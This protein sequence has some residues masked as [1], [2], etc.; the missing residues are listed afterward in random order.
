LLKRTAASAGFRKAAI[1]LGYLAAVFR[2]DKTKRIR[3]DKRIQ[4]KT[5]QGNVRQDCV[6]QDRTAQDRTM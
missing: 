6:K 5:G 1:L 2:Q 3:T 4:R